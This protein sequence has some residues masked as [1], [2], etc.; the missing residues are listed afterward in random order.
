MVPYLYCYSPVSNDSTASCLYWRCYHDH[1][2]SII[3]TARPSG[4]EIP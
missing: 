1:E 2:V 4:V 3:G